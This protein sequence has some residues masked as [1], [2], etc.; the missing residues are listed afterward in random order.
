MTIIYNHRTYR[1]HGRERGEGFGFVFLTDKGWGFYFGDMPIKT[2]KGK[3][4]G[5]FLTANTTQHVANN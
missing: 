3:I 2:D 4:S 1:R 5:F